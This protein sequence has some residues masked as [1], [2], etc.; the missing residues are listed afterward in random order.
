MSY[1]RYIFTNSNGYI[2][3]R[4]P[5]ADT[6]NF[7]L[8]NSGYLEDY[9]NE[10]ENDSES[11]IFNSAVPDFDEAYKPNFYL[12]KFSI[13][14]LLGEYADED[15][16]QDNSNKKDSEIDDLLKKELV[17]LT[18]VMLFFVVPFIS[19]FLGRR[20]MMYCWKSFLGSWIKTP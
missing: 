17:Q 4:N 13:K 19:R 20:F 2:T 5:S 8:P 7:N 14:I 10:A 6:N 18:S 11:G 15:S 9:L 1:D 12:L 16:D 3:F